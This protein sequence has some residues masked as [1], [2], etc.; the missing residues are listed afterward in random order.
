MGHGVH[1]G[2][3]DNIHV[4]EQLSVR[5]TFLRLA[6]T[7]DPTTGHMD[8]PYLLV[9][10]EEYTMDE[11]DELLNTLGQLRAAADASM[12]RSELAERRLSP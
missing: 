5:N 9:D 4:S 6:A 11:L 7:V 3:E 8:G 10:S 2:E 12:A 1:G